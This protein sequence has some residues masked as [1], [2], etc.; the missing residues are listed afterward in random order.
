MYSRPIFFLP[1][2]S[3]QRKKETELKKN[4]FMVFSK[5]P[6]LNKNYFVSGRNMVQAAAEN[7][8]IQNRPK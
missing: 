2:I 7:L 8:I 1:A 3:Y 5:Q 4:F 6:L